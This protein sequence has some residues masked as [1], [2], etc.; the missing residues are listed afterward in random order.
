[1]KQVNQTKNN[2]QTSYMKYLSTTRDCKSD[3][4]NKKHRKKKK[5]KINQ[6]NN[7][8]PSCRKLKG[9]INLTRQ[10][11]Y[12]TGEKPGKGFYRCV[13]CGKIIYLNDDTDT[14]PPCPECHNTSWT[15]A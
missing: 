7:G 8:N 15:R 6:I 14:L 1:M 11:M 4:T 5:Q 10:I 3:G 12:K 9:N 13:V 2:Q